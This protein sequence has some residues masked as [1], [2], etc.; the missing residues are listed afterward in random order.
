M[1][2]VR[3]KLRDDAS[4]DYDKLKTALQEALNADK[5]VQRIAPD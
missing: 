3:R 1:S 5:P 4:E 2:D